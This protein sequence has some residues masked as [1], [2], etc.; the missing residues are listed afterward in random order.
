MNVRDLDYIRAVAKYKHFGQAA[1]HC[2][3]SQ[4]ALSTQIKKLED[5]LGVVIFERD[6]RNVRLTKVGE[7]IIDLAADALSTIEQIRGAAS[8]ARDP[9]SGEF[10]LG[11]IPTIAPYLLPHL[12]SQR[13]NELPQLR[14]QFREDI[15]DRLNESLLSGEIDAA[16]LATAPEDPRLDALPLYDEPFWVI[17]PSRHKLGL[18]KQIRVSD[19][20]DDELLL[21]TEGHC[22]RDQALDVCQV[23]SGR[24]L[25]TIHATSLETLIN[26]VQAEQGI[27][28]VPALAV[29]ESWRSGKGLMCEPLDNENAYRRVYLTY[30][31]SFPRYTL[32]E[33][34]GS[35]LCANLPQNLI[36]LS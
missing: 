26:L 24:Q 35:I 36:A 4:P 15:T 32:I 3:V 21:L 1:E 14:L 29:N 33:K 16:L 17:F 2:N 11:F 10:K 18:A 25:R 13:S 30:R 12:I 8:R 22:F 6:N 27:T 9:L 5:E 28:L 23:S 31:K 20:P 34:I 19:L 7:E